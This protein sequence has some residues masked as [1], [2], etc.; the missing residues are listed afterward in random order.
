M[1]ERMYIKNP[2]I[3]GSDWHDDLAA[4]L[5]YGCV[6]CKT[7]LESLV[8][9]ALN[10]K[11]NVLRA[12]AVSQLKHKST[13]GVKTVYE[14]VLLP[15]YVLFRAYEENLPLYDFQNVQGVIQ[16][17]RNTSGDWRLGQNDRGFADWVFCQ[18]GLIGMSSAYDVGDKVRIYSGPLKDYEGCIIKIDRRSRNGL[19]E[20][21][22]GSKTWR[23]WL[24]FEML[25]V[26]QVS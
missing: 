22:F 1:S 25:D 12:L 7:G 8:A 24:A 14:Q 2:Y 13:N 4:D 20:I 3:A 26:C 23:L 18:G 15:G 5:A 16:V 11:Y 19:V 17:M 9:N 10:Q 6:F 21:K